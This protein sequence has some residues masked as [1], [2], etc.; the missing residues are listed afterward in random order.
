MPDKTGTNIETG[1]ASGDVLDIDGQLVAAGEEAVVRINVGRLPSRTRLNVNVFVFRSQ[2]P[3][4][5]IL[6]L[7]GVHGDEINGIEVVRRSIANDTFRSLKKGSVIAIPLLNVYGFINFSRDVPDGK[8]VNRSFP[9]NMRGSLASRVARVISKAVLPSV[10]YAIDFHTGGA[11]RYNYPQVRF[12]RQSDE[13]LQLAK[14]FAA[15]FMLRKAL[16]R[17]SMRKVARDMG[18]PM[19]VYEGGEALRLDGF[20]IS[21]ATKGLRRVLA[22]KG[23]IDPGPDDGIRAQSIIFE[24]STWVRASYSGIFTWSKQ[25]GA[26]VRR[27]EPIGTITDPYATRVYTV[28]SNKDGFILGHN[29]A[30][31]I[32]QGDALFHIG[33]QTVPLTSDK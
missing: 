2:N 5:V 8:D 14:E 28:K 26:K 33:Y 10:D 25:S 6:M 15:P 1:A 3:G 17:N 27:G 13:S 24:K 19:I 21:S 9:G 4:P 32:N 18:I 11:S 23:M 20:A 16:I 29:N 30:P 7:G 22:A 31:V 12:T